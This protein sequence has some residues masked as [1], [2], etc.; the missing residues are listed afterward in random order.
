MNVVAMRLVAGCALLGAVTAPAVAQTGGFVVTLGS[1]TMQVER[2]ARTAGR[3]EGVVVTRAP[4]TRVMRWSLA[5]GADGRPARYDMAMSLPDGS[6]LRGNAQAGSIAFAADSATRETLRDGQV[7]TQRIASPPGML[8]PGPG[9]PFLGV[10]IAMYELAFADARRAASDAGES[11]VHQ[12][13]MGAGQMQPGQTRVWFI[14]ADSVEMDYFGVA[15]RGF[16]LDARGQVVHADWSATTYK[17]QM[18]RV[19]DLDVES[20]AQRWAAAE[21]SGAV[22]GAISPVDTVRA[23]V[24]SAAIAVTYSR[25]SKRGRAIWGSLVPWDRVWRFGADFATHFST[26][27][28]LVIGTTTVPAGRY[29]LWMLPSQSGESMLIVS[30]AVNV[31]GTQYNPARDLARIPMRRDET[32]APAERFTISVVDGRLWATWDRTAWSVPVAVK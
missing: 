4:Q 16:R 10:S 15:R 24:G 26:S 32:R 8:L 29:T 7:V 14:G 5:F 20:I 21:R 3:L 18:A 25:P 11:A 19:A 2:F 31:F 27:A 12:I 23:T 30:S 13:T 17:Y 1:D 6:P 28:D 22:M 9:L